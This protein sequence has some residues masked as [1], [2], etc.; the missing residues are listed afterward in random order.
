MS[1]PFALQRGGKAPRV[2]GNT[3]VRRDTHLTLC[4]SVLKLRRLME[5]DFST[6]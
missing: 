1:R 4:S 6:Q 2:V 5:T 3:S